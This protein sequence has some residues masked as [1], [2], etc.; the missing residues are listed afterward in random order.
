MSRWLPIADWHDP[1][2]DKPAALRRLELFEVY[3]SKR[4]AARI[5]AAKYQIPSFKPLT[6][7]TD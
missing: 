5:R 3:I 2:A 1:Y 4:K 6:K 7:S